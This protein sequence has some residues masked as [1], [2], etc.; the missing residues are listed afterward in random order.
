[1]CSTFYF[2]LHLDKSI[3][4]YYS[5]MAILN[6]ILWCCTIVLYSFLSM[7]S[8]VIVFWSSASPMYFSFWRIPWTVLLY[9][10]FFPPVSIPSFSKLFAISK[11][12]EPSKY[13]LYILLT[14][15]ASSSSIIN[16]LFSSLVY[17]RKWFVLVSYITSPAYLANIIVF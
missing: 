11:K 12:L 5:F 15:F 7:K 6:I 4:W 16:F 14:T 2:F 1:M 9:H 3:S 13:S 10:F 8:T 17:P